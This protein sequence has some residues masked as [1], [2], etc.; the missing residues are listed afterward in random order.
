MF[1]VLTALR[2][3]LRNRGWF[4]SMNI[5]MPN[6]ADSLDLVALV[7]WRTLFRSTKIIERWLQRALH[8]C[9][10]VERDRIE[11]LFEVAGRDIRSVTST[12]LGFVAGPRI[13]AAGRL[14]DMSVGIECLLS[15]STAARV[16]LRRS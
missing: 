4:E 2:A 10:Q 1:Y 16:L 15:E 7:R 13:N 8:A 3:E 5:E 12:D 9:A 14:D 11:A 6:L